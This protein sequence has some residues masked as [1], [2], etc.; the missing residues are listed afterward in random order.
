VSADNL[1]LFRILC[2]RNEREHCLVYKP[3][4]DWATFDRRIY[5]PALIYSLHKSI[6]CAF[7]V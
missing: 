2:Y 4:R 1:K 6:T 3:S 7:V 5:N